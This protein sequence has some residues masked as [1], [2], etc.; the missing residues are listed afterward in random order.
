MGDDAPRVLPE[1]YYLDNFELLVRSVTETYADILSDKEAAF[2]DDFFSLS[3]AARRLYVR[4]VS[5]RGPLFRSDL[6]SYPEI[7]PIDGVTRELCDAELASIGGEYE[8]AEA[9]RL[10]RVGEL[11]GAFPEVPAGIRKQEAVDWV[12]EHL[13]PAT[14][15]ATIEAAEPAFDVIEI[16]RTEIVSTCLLLFFGNA[17]QD[18]SEFVITDL[19][20]VTYERYDI[21]GEMRPFTDRQSVDAVLAYYDAAERLAELSKEHDAA[22]LLALAEECRAIEFPRS[23]GHRR[24]RL[25]NGIARQLEREGLADDAAS[26]YEST[27]YPPSRE[28]RARIEV[29]RGSLAGG[30]RLLEEILRAPLSEDE[31][32]FAR[33]FGARQ[34]RRHGA[35]FIEVPSDPFVPQ[36]TKARLGNQPGRSVEEIALDHYL[37][38]GYWGSWCENALI[39]GL[40]GLAFWDI[41]FA[42]VP[43]VFFNRY[44]R[45]PADLHLP[46]FRQAREDAFVA[47]MSDIRSDESWRDAVMRKFR[48]KQGVANALLD[49]RQLTEELV[50][51]ALDRIPTEHL[52]PLFD[53][54]SRDVA[55]NGSG[56]PDLALFPMAGGAGDYLLVEV[57]GPGD[58][59]QKNQLRWMRRFEEIGVPYTVL[60][61]EWKE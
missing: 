12:A 25:L 19:G 42:P 38:V 57:K 15:R 51:L 10:L 54:I 16:L 6:L 52:L 2:V 47:R 31:A 14:I 48:E 27:R 9:L 7:G 45:G 28:R 29:A 5:R 60:W 58:Q 56:F 55:A 21:D 50:L 33:S 26:L 49:W 24:D 32:E 44:Q 20:L 61:I 59:L 39:R 18:L 11:R 46:D 23:L 35:P 30:A 22:G 43:G 8:V 36:T 4:L 17:R 1:G 3:I 34:F 13:D 41:I 40:F 37:A 53:R